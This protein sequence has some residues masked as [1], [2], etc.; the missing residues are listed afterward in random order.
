MRTMR[1]RTSIGHPHVREAFQR[2]VVASFSESSTTREHPPPSLR[3]VLANTRIQRPTLDDVQRLSEGRAAKTRGWGSRQTPHRL[4]ADE[5]TQYNVALEKS[6]LTIKGTGYRKERKGAPLANIYR[7]YCD[8]KAVPCVNLLLA[9]TS[10]VV[11][12]EQTTT[13]RWRVDDEQGIVV[14]E[15]VTARIEER[16][17]SSGGDGFQFVTDRL[18][19]AGLVPWTV[20]APPEV[21]EKNT[22]ELVDEELIEH[23]CSS[24]I[25][26]IPVR[27]VAVQVADRALAKKM[28]SEVGGL[29]W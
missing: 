11:L 17:R 3:T 12:V 6:Y 10:N 5:R 23:Y 1:I 13:R 18:A 25:W 14:D 8:A 29:A 24:A 26:T 15:A 20:L 9:G 21:I 4:N 27:V 2:R 7:Q 28:A 22:G 19:L 16:L